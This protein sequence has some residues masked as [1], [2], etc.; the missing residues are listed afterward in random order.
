[1]NKLKVIVDGEIAY[2]ST[3]FEDK[4]LLRESVS[5]VIDG[6]GTLW[7][8]LDDGRTLMLPAGMIQKSVFVI[9]E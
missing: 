5:E 4:E 6:G 2:L 8:D 7:L 3:P 1:M 9:Y